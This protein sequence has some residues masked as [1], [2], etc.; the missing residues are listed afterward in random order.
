M[1]DTTAYDDASEVVEEGKRQSESLDSLAEY[2]AE[3]RTMGQQCETIFGAES[4]A[5]AQYIGA[6]SR[7]VAGDE[8]IR[9]QVAGLES[10]LAAVAVRVKAATLRA[11]IATI[12]KIARPAAPSGPPTARRVISAPPFR[13][14]HLEAPLV[15]DAFVSFF[16][17]LADAP[18]ALSATIAASVSA[19]A[20]PASQVSALDGGGPRPTNPEVTPARADGRRREDA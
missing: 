4:R 17:S 7:T 1:A 5:S 12:E 18:P 19:P 15:R 10:E 9:M 3:L 13:P 16:D 8:A 11:P 2:L 14:T 20:A 6:I